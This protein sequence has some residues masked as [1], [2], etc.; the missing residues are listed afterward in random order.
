MLVWRKYGVDGRANGA[1]AADQL[2]CMKGQL[3]GKK[4]YMA[5]F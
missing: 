3:H 5:T 1:A 4:W 2:I